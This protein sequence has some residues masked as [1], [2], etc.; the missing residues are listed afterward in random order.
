[1][2]LNGGEK[3]GKEAKI[4]TYM[5]LGWCSVRRETD[6]KS[7]APALSICTDNFSV[8]GE[9]LY[10]RCR[11]RGNGVGIIYIYNTVA[12]HILKGRRSTTMIKALLSNI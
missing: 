11:V 10:S 2:S 6:A 8:H 1:M 12:V 7:Q 9:S 5:S 4:S 3:G